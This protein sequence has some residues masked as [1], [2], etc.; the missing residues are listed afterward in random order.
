MTYIIIGG[1]VIGASAAYHLSKHTDTAIRVLEKTD[2]PFAEATAKSSLGFR[3]YANDEVKIR[4]RQHA[5]R[6]YNKFLANSTTGGR[7]V[8]QEFIEVATTEVGSDT[9]RQEIK[10]GAAAKSSA[11]EYLQG[12]ELDSV[13]L[14]PGLDTTSVVGAAYRPNSGFFDTPETVGYEFLNRAVRNGVTFETNMYVSD[15]TTDDGRVTGVIVDD[16]W[17][18]ATAVICAAGSRNVKLSQKVGIDLPIRHT[19]VQIMEFEPEE[20][21][22][23]LL[24]RVAHHESGAVF[25]GRTNG[26]VLNYHYGPSP[27]KRVRSSLTAY[28]M[29]CEHDPDTFNYTTPSNHKRKIRDIGTTILPCIADAE[30]TMQD[31]CLLSRTPDAKPIVGWTEVEDFFIAALPSKG[32]QYAPAVGYVIASQVVDNNPTEYYKDVSVTRFQKHNDTKTTNDE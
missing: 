1:G 26:N 11:A 32:I 27:D 16:E 19:P 8:S 10:A 12:D 18:G 5:K 31:V 2:S 7:Y 20:S 14:A 13:V 23:N 28:E 17:I 3:H 15:I 25:R 6:L 29:G 4:M 21:N 24:P 9:L 22:S 30:I